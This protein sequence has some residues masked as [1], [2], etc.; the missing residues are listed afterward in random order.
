LKDY[1]GGKTF[2]DLGDPAP[3]KSHTLKSRKKRRIKRRWESEAQGLG[4]REL[5]V[6]S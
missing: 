2:S 3:R 6:K 4:E 5:E 1:A